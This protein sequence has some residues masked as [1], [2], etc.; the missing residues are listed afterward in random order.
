MKPRSLIRRLCCAFLILL[1]VGGAPAQS[2]SLTFLNDILG[3]PAS[4]EAKSRALPASGRLLL[5]D[6]PSNYA[7]YESLE[8]QMRELAVEVANGADMLSYYRL[9]DSVLGDVIEIA[10]SIRGLLV[11]RSDGVLDASDRDAID[12]EIGQLYDQVA[13]SLRDA[14]FNGKKLFL[15]SKTS[16]SKGLLGDSRRLEPGAVDNW[17]GTLIADRGEIRAKIEAF[18]DSIS[19]KE[20][21]G[22]EDESSLRRSDGE[23]PLE[24]SR[25][26]RSRLV[27]LADVLM[28]GRENR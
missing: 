10:Q 14:E 1:A 22:L 21:E 2:A 23:F 19:G 26:E 9:E 25:L 5:A 4:D 7:L 18:E 15:D 24:L 28:L 11:Q 27:F 8:G 13:E 17:L 6:D 3:N 16:A 20:D 12:G